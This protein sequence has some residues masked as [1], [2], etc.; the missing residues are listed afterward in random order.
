MAKAKQIKEIA[1]VT[2]NKAGMLAEVT[3]AI[4]SAG[5]NIIAL[6]AYSMGDKA[7]FLVVT[8]NNEKAMKV[9]KNKKFEVKED[10]VL[11]VALSNKVGAVKELA[12]KL[13]KSG[14][15]LDYCYGSTGDGQ[16][17]LLVFSTKDIKRAL[18]VCGG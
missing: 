13:Q 2:P 5:V 17:S 9:L 16:E 4:A 10:D 1:A 14:V 18:E 3:N 7:K 15:D 6:N 12:D 8:D 11:S